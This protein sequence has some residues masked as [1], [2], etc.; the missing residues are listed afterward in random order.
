M[1][2]IETKQLQEGA[3]LAQPVIT[4]LG[5]PLAPAGSAVTRQLINRMKLYRV[6]YAEIEGEEPAPQEEAPKPVKEAK[7]Y[8]QESKTHSQKV[9]GSSEFRTFQIEYV[10]AI[11]LMKQMY[12]AAIKDNKPIDSQKL[13]GSVADLFQ[14]RNTIVEMFMRTV[15][16]LH[17]FHE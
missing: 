4:P 9:A 2:K 14:S 5:Q 7:T 10:Q 13:L 16:T 12:T 11:E 8:A 1:I 17:S 15:S 6:E 3:I